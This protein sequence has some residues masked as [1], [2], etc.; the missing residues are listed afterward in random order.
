MFFLE[1]GMLRFLQKTQV[2][3]FPNFRPK[4]DDSELFFFE[5]FGSQNEAKKL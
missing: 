3:M 4:F 2:A 5:I 1:I